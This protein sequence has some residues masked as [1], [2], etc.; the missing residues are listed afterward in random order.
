MGTDLSL[1]L[2]NKSPVV[3]CNPTPDLN[4]P[5][6]PKSNVCWYFIE[7]NGS[8][9]INEGLTRYVVVPAPNAAAATP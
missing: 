7:F 4:V 2:F 8:F 9:N 5:F 6:F 3:P 1:I